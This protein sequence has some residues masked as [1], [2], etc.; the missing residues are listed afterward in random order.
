MDGIY[1]VTVVSCCTCLWHFLES[2]SF[3]FLSDCEINFFED[4]KDSFS[5]TEVFNLN[6]AN[7]PILLKKLDCN[8]YS[9]LQEHNKLRSCCRTTTHKK[10][11]RASFCLAAWFA[12][13][14]AKG[15]IVWTPMRFL[16]FKFC[17][18]FLITNK[19]RNRC[20][21]ASSSQRSKRRFMPKN[22]RKRNCKQNQRY[23]TINNCI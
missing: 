6:Y 13:R 14:K 19:N 5:N 15:G 7:E 17:K 9:Q 1:L 22:R 16:P 11:Q 3:V 12:S 10:E 4:E 2:D 23:R 18:P 20:L 8:V 21:F